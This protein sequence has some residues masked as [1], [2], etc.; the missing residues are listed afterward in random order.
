LQIFLNSLNWHNVSGI[1]FDSAFVDASFDIDVPA[2]SPIGSPRIAD[3]PEVNSIEITPSD[4]DYGVIQFGRITRRIVV[5][6]TSM[7]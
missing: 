3:D 6:T 1:E 7:F 4:D 2:S 5:N